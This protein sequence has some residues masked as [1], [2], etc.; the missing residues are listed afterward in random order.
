MTRLGPAR[1]GHTRMAP[2][3]LRH[4]V[5]AV[6]AD[7]FGVRRNDV[8]AALQDD[9]GKLGVNLLVRL[10]APPLLVRAAVPTDSVDRAA[11]DMA[12]PDRERPALFEPVFERARTARRQIALLGGRI[13]GMECGRISIR[14]AGAGHSPSEPRVDGEQDRRKA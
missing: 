14:L 11:P 1:Q 8:S 6:A 12:A 2:A 9:A 7:A 5:E 4:A 10:P 13:T 3:A